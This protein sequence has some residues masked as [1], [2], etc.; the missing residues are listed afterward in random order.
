MAASRRSADE[1]HPW[2]P[3]GDLRPFLVSRDIVIQRPLRNNSG[4]SAP[5]I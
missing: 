1:I 2:V 3:N 4:H 5:V